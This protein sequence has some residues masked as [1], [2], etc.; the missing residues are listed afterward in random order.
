M[1][2]DSRKD[3]VDNLRGGL[4]ELIVIRNPWLE[5]Y[6]RKGFEELISSPPEILIYPLFMQ[7]AHFGKGVLRSPRVTSP[8]HDLIWTFGSW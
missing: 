5:V 8:V 7:N 4:L 3:Q 2:G 6:Q 1:T